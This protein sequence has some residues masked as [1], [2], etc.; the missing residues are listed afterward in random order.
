MKEKGNDEGDGP[1][2]SVMKAKVMEVLEAAEVEIVWATALAAGRSGNSGLCT[3]ATGSSENGGKRCGGRARAS[4]GD[5]CGGAC[6]DLKL[7]QTAKAA[8]LKYAVVEIDR[9]VAV[10]DVNHCQP[11]G[12]PPFA[13]RGKPSGGT[14]QRRKK[15]RK[16]NR[17]R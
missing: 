14:L 1:L 3:A 12:S 17:Q 4:G 16:K 15:Q 13:N 6:R 7:R 10:V 5:G 8:S 11:P 2:S 9:G